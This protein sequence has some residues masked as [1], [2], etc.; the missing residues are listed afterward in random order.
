M[1]YARILFILFV[2]TWMVGGDILKMSHVLYRHGARSPTRFFPTNPNQID[3]WPD[4][5]GRL[6]QKGMMLEYN[7]GQFLKER[8]VVTKFVNIS[9]LHE[10]IY[11]RSSNID[12][13][14]QSAEA[15]LAA[16]YPP[17]GRQV[18]KEEL[19]W[20][21]IPVHTVPGAEDVLLRPTENCPRISQIRSKMIQ[22][23]EIKKKTEENKELLKYMT[24]NSG[25]NITL[26]NIWDVTDDILCEQYEGMNSAGWV[27]KRFPEILNLSNYAFNYIYQGSDELGRLLG[28]ALLGEMIENMKSVHKE[29]TRT[30]KL[31]IYSG[32]DTS[33]LALSTAFNIKFPIPSF[34]ACI[35][36]ELRQDD[37]M[38]YYVTIDYRNGLDDNA[39]ITQMNLPGCVYKCPLQ[40]FVKLTSKRIPLNRQKECGLKKRMLTKKSLT[41]ITIILLA[42]TIFLLIVFVWVLI[43]YRCRRRVVKAVEK[44][45]NAFLRDDEEDDFTDDEDFDE[46]TALVI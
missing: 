31:N 23:D 7:L 35:M 28:G 16:L 46:K 38:N 2:E 34:S 6:T 45:Q 5:T 41:L 27:M 13:C 4:G 3:A 1:F 19:S 10:E 26:L 11:I 40:D 25:E 22:S 37:R 17:K 36:V 8:Y 12:R 20:Q 21:P 15:Q 14:L 18:W 29:D 39:T 42:S 44:K 30:H 32:H 43:R 33:I 9:Y 24:E